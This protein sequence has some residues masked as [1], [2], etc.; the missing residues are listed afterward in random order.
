M[1]HNPFVALG[2][3]EQDT[4]LGSKSACSDL[5]IVTWE[6]QDKQNPSLGNRR[7][8]FSDYSFEAVFFLFVVVCCCFFNLSISKIFT[9]TGWW[10][11]ETQTL[12]P[13]WNFGLVSFKLK[14]WNI[15]WG[16][17]KILAGRGIENS[18]C[19]SPVPGC[20]A[21]GCP[22]PECR[23]PSRQGTQVAFLAYLCM[24]TP[25]LYRTAPRTCIWNI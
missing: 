21:P 20:R 14:E 16:R 18:F 7:K 12:H 5:T 6:S 24:G 17:I 9:L 19:L 10:L 15:Q 4:N 11:E 1:K 8:I 2:P 23:T 3:L 13:V 22:G 25:C